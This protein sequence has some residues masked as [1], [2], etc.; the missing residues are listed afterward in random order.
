MAACG[1]FEKK[2]KVVY[3]SEMARNAIESDFRSS[4]MAQKGFS[5]WPPAAIFKK[6]VAYW[7]E[8][9]RNAFKSDF[10][11]S[12]MA[13]GSHFVKKKSKLRIDLKWRE[14]WS[15]VI[16]GH[17]KWPLAA[18][19]WKK[20]KVAYWSEMVRNAIESDFRSSKMAAGSHFVEKNQKNKSCV[21]IWNGDKCDRKWFLVIQNGRRQPFCEQ[22]KKFSIDLKWREMRL[23][24]QNACRQPFVK[25]KS[26]IALKWREVRS[27]FIFGHPKW[28]GGGGGGG[29]IKMAIGQP[30]NHLGIY[31]VFALAPI[32]VFTRL[33]RNIYSIRMVNNKLV[34]EGVGN[35]VTGYPSVNN[36]TVPDYP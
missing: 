9:A 18:I 24:I 6:K 5:K 30:V 36:R 22:N 7:S 20:I 32:L 26:S 1:H 27:K 28:G 3:W 19:L 13:A 21:L 33:V 12:K 15:K 17:P 34:V 29:G 4:K 25:K 11:S 16:F 8:M 31:T 10:R 2:K 35:F 23:V 14:M